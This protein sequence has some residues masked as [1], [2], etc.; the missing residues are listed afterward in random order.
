M[1]GRQDARDRIGASGVR[2][3]GDGERSWNLV[4]LDPK[5]AEAVPVVVCGSRTFVTELVQAGFELRLSTDGV[6]PA[7]ECRVSLLD[8]DAGPGIAKPHLARP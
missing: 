4:W 7:S 3:A 6:E 2:P 1:E 8:P 5:T